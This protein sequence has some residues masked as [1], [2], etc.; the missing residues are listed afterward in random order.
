MQAMENLHQ[1]ASGKSSSIQS[2]HRY[3]TKLTKILS[4]FFGGNV[5]FFRKLGLVGF[6][7]DCCF[8]VDLWAGRQ[9]TA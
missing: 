4:C 6:A 1:H 7:M 9:V 8:S 5:G 3:I 2:K